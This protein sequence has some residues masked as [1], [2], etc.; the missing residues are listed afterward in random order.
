MVVLTDRAYLVIVDGDDEA[1][2]EFQLNFEESS[3]LS[4]NYVVG[5]RG[6]YIREIEQINPFDVSLETTGERRTGFW[7]DGG[8]GEWQHTLSFQTGL[9]DV[10]WGDGSNDE[11]KDASGEGVH[12]LR[13]KDVLEHWLANTRSDSGGQVRLHW[14]GWT[15]GDIPH[16]SG[17]D[18]GP[19]NRPMFVAVREANI[20]APDLNEDINS[21]EGTL[22][23]NRVAL[24]PD[25][26][27]TDFDD[28]ADLVRDAFDEVIP[29]F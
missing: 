26:V 4:K 28:A 15:D 1:T 8:A 14:S 3:E 23:V 2:F 21:V 7:V 22:T 20:D 6:Q 16:V 24:I 27:P 17:V 5:Q 25:A 19:Y 29:D 12:P 9:E 18:A 13:R 11:Q 10:Q